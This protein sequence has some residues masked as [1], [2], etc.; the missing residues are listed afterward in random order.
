[1]DAENSFDSQNEPQYISIKLEPVTCFEEHS[2]LEASHNNKD[3]ISNDHCSHSPAAQDKFIDQHSTNQCSVGTS[4]SSVNEDSI[5]DNQSF[6]ENM[7]CSLQM[8]ENVSPE[9]GE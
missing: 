5:V 4:R 1:M 6:T 7:N 8:P 9:E 2:L 3:S